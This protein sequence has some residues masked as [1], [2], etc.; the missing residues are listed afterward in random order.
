VIPSEAV[1]SIWRIAIPLTAEVQRTDP[2]LFARLDP[3][4]T[5][6]RVSDRR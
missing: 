6:L 4:L 2:A 5:E 1:C 3:G